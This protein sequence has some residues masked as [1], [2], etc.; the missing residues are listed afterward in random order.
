MSYNFGDEKLKTV[1]EDTIMLAKLLDYNVTTHIPREEW[2][3][4]TFIKN[5]IPVIRIQFYIDFWLGSK[6]VMSVKADEQSIDFDMPVATAIESKIIV[7]EKLQE[8]L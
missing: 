1:V 6:P 2:Y 7:L 5:N 4:I 8:Q 3:V